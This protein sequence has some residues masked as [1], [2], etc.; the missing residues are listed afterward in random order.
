MIDDWITSLRARGGPP[1]GG[2]LAELEA[3]LFSEGLHTL[4]QKPSAAE[5]AGT[6]P[7]R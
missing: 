4:G 3:S 5:M 1:L 6:L 7:E 2:Y